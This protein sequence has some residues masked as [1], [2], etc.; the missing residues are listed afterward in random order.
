[1]GRLVIIVLGGGVSMGSNF[2]FEKRRECN[3]LWGCMQQPIAKQSK[4]EITSFSFGPPLRYIRGVVCRLF[5]WRSEDVDVR[6]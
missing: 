3:T 5:L 6:E 2:C 4:L 1:M